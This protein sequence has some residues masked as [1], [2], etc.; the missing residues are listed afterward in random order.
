MVGHLEPTGGGQLSICYRDDMGPDI[1]VVVTLSF[2]ARLLLIYCSSA[3]RLCSS[4]ARLLLVYCSSI[5]L[6]H[7]LRL[8][9]HQ[10]RTR[11]LLMLML[12]WNQ[13]PLRSAAARGCHGCGATDGATDG[14][15]GQ[16]Q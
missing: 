9:L 8:L 15:H 16:C 10:L 11:L 5:R 2:Q 14:A 3:A 1:I 4:T 13:Q 6:R 12:Y 7:H